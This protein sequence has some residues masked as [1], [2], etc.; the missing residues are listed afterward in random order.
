MFEYVLEKSK[1]WLT[2]LQFGDTMK[3]KITI[4]IKSICMKKFADDL[5]TNLIAK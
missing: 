4:D 5:Y 3:Y 2:I 1:K